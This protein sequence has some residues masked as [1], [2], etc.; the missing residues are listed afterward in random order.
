MHR[1]Q[2]IDRVVKIESANFNSGEYIP[3][4]SMHYPKVRYRRP[5]TYIW[6]G[7][8]DFNKKDTAKYVKCTLTAA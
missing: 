6:V 1:G 5:G 4:L 7:K 3:N 8:R 2:E